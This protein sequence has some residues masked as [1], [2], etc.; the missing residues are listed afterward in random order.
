MKNKGITLISLVITIILLIILAGIGIKLSLGENGLFN[1]AKYAKEKYLNEQENEE[2]KLNDLYSQILV[3]TGED[4]KITISTKELQEIIQEEVK[5][6]VQQP[7]GIKKDAFIQNSMTNNSNY[8]TINSMSNL[9]KKTA[10][11]NNKIE[12]YLS[13]SNE[14]GYTVLKSG[15]YFVNIMVE[16]ASPGGAVDAGI[17][18]ILNGAAIATSSAWTNSRF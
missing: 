5:K 12:E 8:K 4:A 15:W 13:Y 10:D 11:E 9:W 6:S 7:T 2:K 18:C 14:D 1:K 16:L 17:Y 3:A